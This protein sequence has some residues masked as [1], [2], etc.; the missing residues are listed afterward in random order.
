MLPSILSAEQ[1]RRAL[2]IRDLTDPNGGPHALQLL[3]DA[4]ITALRSTWGL[5]VLVTRRSPIVSI[6]D[7]YDELGYSPEAAARDSRYTRYVCDVALLRTQ[8]SAMLPPLLRELAR[9]PLTDVLLACPGITYRRDSI[10][11]LHTGEP[12][13]LD[14]WRIRP[15]RLGTVDL[16]EMIDDVVGAMLPE[17]PVRVSP[18]EH[19]YTTDGLQIDV[20]TS[21]GWVEI[22]ECGLAH[23]ELLARSG[24]DPKGVGGLAMGIGLDRVLMVQKGIGDIRLLR[25]SDARI[26]RQMLDLEPYRPVSSMPAVRRDLSVALDADARVENLGDQVREALA[27]DADLVE[28]VELLSETPYAE[29]PPAAIARMGVEPHQK[30]ALVRVVLRALDRTLTHDE[31]NALR[32]RIYAALHRGSTSEWAQRC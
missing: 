29:L 3:V 12:H 8:T 28:S 24:L 1:V 15:G 11:R 16:R 32:D 7:N 17:R 22:G 18:T 26:A 2:S 5:A 23:P 21:R 27:D 4:A 9:A 6:G 25:S 14:L 30:N 19:P 20:E 13:Q 31:C 10:D